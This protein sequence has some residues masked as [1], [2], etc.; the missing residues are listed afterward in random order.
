MEL[1]PKNFLSVKGLFFS[2]EGIDGCGKTTQLKRF[3]LYLQQ[4]NVPFICT[5]EPGGNLVSE[6]IRKILLSSNFNI[7]PRCELLLFSASRTQLCEEVIKPN[8]DKGICV[9]CDRFYDSTTAYQGYGRNFDYNLINQLNQIS[10]DGLN[11]HITFLFD[12]KP[13]IAK[14]RI[15]RN[16]DRMENNSIEFFE[17]VRQGF[18]IQARNNLRYIVLD[19]S[20]TEDEVYANMIKSIEERIC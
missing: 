11:P 17:R 18:L 10:T 7:V 8:L 15:S 2:F 1:E 9:L 16:F 12:L 14:K 3:S 19:A 20:K 4:K 6:E 5:R 13:E